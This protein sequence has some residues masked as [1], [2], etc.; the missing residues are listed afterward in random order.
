MIDVG[1][2]PD[3]TPAQVA[4]SKQHYE[5]ALSGVEVFKRVL[6]LH[7]ARYFVE[8][9]APKA[10]G[11]KKVDIFDEMLRSG[12]LFT[13]AHGDIESPVAHTAMGKLGRDTVAR[14]VGVAKEKRFFHWEL[15]FPEVF[16]GRQTGSLNSVGRLPAAGFD[17]IIGN[18]PY[19]VLASEELGRDVSEELNYFRSLQEFGPAG[20]G[21]MNFYKLFICKARAL[22]ILE[23]CVSLIVPMA[24][25]GDEQSAGVRKLLLESTELKSIESFPQKDDP[26]RRVFPEAKLSTAVFHFRAGSRNCKFSV[27]THPGGTLDEISGRLDIESSE[28]LAFDPLNW[29]IPSCTQEDFD[30]AVRMLKAGKLRRMTEIATSYQGEVNETNERKRGVFKTKDELPIALRGANLC[31]YAVR[32][33]SQGE[34]LHMDIE[35]FLKGK[36]KE[37]KAYDFKMQRIGFQRSSPQ[38]NFRRIIA[39]RIP[40]GSHCLDTVSYITSDSTKVDFELLLVLLNSK[41]LD[42]YFRLGSTNSKV[43]EYQFNALPVP[44]IVESEAGHKI[45]QLVQD[46]ERAKDALVHALTAPGIMPRF[47][48]EALV[49]LCRNIEAVEAKRHLK[50]RSDRSRL[51]PESQAFQDAIDAILFRCYGLSEND[52]K[53]VEARLK[54][55]L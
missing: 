46:P 39:A 3:I 33:A 13:W 35:Q 52:Q 2:M 51:A 31:L 12:E 5:S 23:G 37:S 21:K 6:N 44:T 43:N 55:M 42:W 40:K 48:K 28:V 16:Y 24:L 54:V 11:T 10:R 49:L 4:S 1:G 27:T 32:D 14:S 17:A 47:V 53:F 18:P 26:S 36:G 29:A 20:G 34:E 50:T 45:D 15:E 9:E 41:V 22:A 25:L 8:I 38:N 7:T 19:D 30:L